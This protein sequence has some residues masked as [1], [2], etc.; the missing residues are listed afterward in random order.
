[1]RF[2]L[3]E[4]GS[5]GRSLA[6]EASTART[7][8]EVL[9]WQVERR[10]DETA[11][12]FLPDGE[13]SVEELSY[14]SLA[15]R[16][17]A[18]AS[19]LRGRF[20]SGDRAIILFESV[21]DFSVAFFGCLYAKVIPVPL[22]ARLNRR[23]ASVVR[24]IA[25]DAGAEVFLSTEAGAS[26]AASLSMLGGMS[27]VTLKDVGES[28]LASAPPAEAYDFAFLQYT[29]GSTNDPKGVMVGHENLLENMRMIRRSF[30]FHERSVMVSWLPHHHDMGLIGTVLAPI[31]LGIPSVLMKPIHFAQNPMRWLRAISRFGGTVSGG[32]DFGYD[33]CSRAHPETV[34]ELDLSSWEVAFSGAEPVRSATLDRFENVF[35]AAG[36]RRTS[37]LPC[38]GLA[39]GTLLAAGRSVDGGAQ[40]Q[41]FD[42]GRLAEGVAE[43]ATDAVTGRDLVGCL[44]QEGTEVAIVN[45]RGQKTEDG[46]AGEIWI[47]G[48][49][50][51]LGYW[52][53]PEESERTFRAGL[54]G[55]GRTYLRTGDIGFR[56]DSTL[57][58]LGRAKDLIIVRGQNHHPEDIET[59]VASCDRG[60]TILRSA[61]FGVDEGHGERVAVLVEIS[62]SDPDRI[63]ALTRRVRQA[64]SEEHGVDA[65]TVLAV[66]PRTIPLTTSGKVRRRETARLYASAHLSPKEGS[67]EEGPERGMPASVAVATPDDGG[68]DK[69]APVLRALAARVLRVRLDALDNTLPLTAQGLDSLKAAEFLELSEHVLGFRPSLEA[70]LG[71]VPLGEIAHAMSVS[72]APPQARYGSATEVD[73]GP[74]PLSYGQRTLWFQQE[75]AVDAMNLNLARAVSIR[76]PLDLDALHEAFRALLARHSALRTRYCEYSGQVWQQPV[77]DVP[78]DIARVSAEAWSSERLT[79][80]LEEAAFEPFSL[81]SPP[82]LRAAVYQRSEHQNILLVV[83]H[84]SVID[85]ESLFT[86]IRSL[87]SAYASATGLSDGGEEPT[88]KALPAEFVRWQRQLVGNETGR[89]LTRYWQDQLE[90]AAKLDLPTDRVRPATRSFRGASHPFR[91]NVRTLHGIKHLAGSLGIGV[92]SLLF[93][94]YAVLLGRYSGEHRFLL[95]FVHSGRTQSYFADLVG[96]LVNLLPIHIDMEGTPAFDMFARDLHRHLIRAYDY[97]DFPYGKMAEEIRHAET[98]VGEGHV[99][100][101]FAFQRA[102][103]TDEL[104]LTPLVLNQ[105]GR[106]LEREGIEIEVH[107]LRQHACYF[108]LSLYIGEDSDELLCALEYSTDL[109]EAETIE[110]LSRA[111]EHLLDEICSAPEREVAVLPLMSADEERQIVE[112]WNDTGRFQGEECVHELFERQVR[113]APDA[114]AVVDENGTTTYRELNETANRL[115]HRLIGEGCGPGTR[116]GVLMERSAT[117]IAVILGI[118]KSGAA[119]VPLDRGYPRQRLEFIFA[120]AGVE[121]LVGPDDLTS[122]Y[123]DLQRIDPDEVALFGETS[124]VGCRAGLDDTAYVV[125][126]SGSTGRPNGVL[127][128]H[129]GIVNRQSWFQ[130]HYPF[131]VGEVG[132]HKTSLSFFDSGGEIFLPLVSGAPLVVASES[133]GRD[134]VALTELLRR[135]RVTRLVAVPSLLKSMLDS[136]PDLGDRLAALRYCHSSGESLPRDVAWRF[137]EQLPNC[138]LIDLYGS[139]EVSADATL[140][141]L[142]SPDEA[143]VIGR[144]LSGVRVYV[145]GPGMVPLPPRFPGEIH[146]AGD[147]LA[148]GYLG[149][150]ELTEAKMVRDPFSKNPDAR[151]FRTGDRAR[152]HVDGNLEYLGRMDHQV[153]I[154][155]HRVEIG[156]I[157]AV[158]GDHPRVRACAVTTVSP[159]GAGEQQLVAALTPTD[160]GGVAGGGQVHRVEGWRQLYDRMYGDAGADEERQTRIWTDSYTGEPFTS[161]VMS[162]W[163]A[164]AMDRALGLEPRNVLE[165]GCGT[166][167]LAL[168]LVGGG[169]SYVGTDF[170]TEGLQVARERLREAGLEGQA[171]LLRREAPD[172]TGLR[173]EGYDTV[174]L[175]SVTQYLP[176]QDYLREVLAA[177]V[178][179]TEEGGNVF[180]GDVR[181]LD[182]SEA[183]HTSV[184][185]AHASPTELVGQIRNRIQRRMAEDNELVVARAFF[186]GLVHEIP[187]VTNVR[188]L[189]KRGRQANELTSF[190]Y[191]VVLQVGD[192]P[193][194]SRSPERLHWSEVGSDVESLAARISSGLPRPLEVRGVTNARAQIHASRVDLLRG[195]R[196]DE[197][198]GLLSDDVMTPELDPESVG[199]LTRRLT[200]HVAVVPEVDGD[201]N[202]M[203]VRVWPEGEPEPL[204]GAVPDRGEGVRAELTNNPLRT[205]SE[206]ELLGD[207]RRH[208]RSRLPEFMVPKLR[209]MREL[210]TTDTGKVSRIEVRRLEEFRLAGSAGQ[211]TGAGEGTVGQGLEAEVTAI[212]QQVLQVEPSRADDN[213]FDIGG[214]SLSLVQVH[215]RLQE[216]T[217]VEF[218]LVDLY[219]HTTVRAIAEFLSRVGSVTPDGRSGAEAGVKRSGRTKESAL[220]IQQR[221]SALAE[222]RRRRGKQAEDE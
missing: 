43:P 133:V 83:G 85:L 15:L 222:R 125:Y 181:D 208:L 80:E 153:Q 77:R 37:F 170:S 38:Y 106:L 5:H 82:L 110:A 11:L 162:E 164:N 57:F 163:L 124:N 216:L 98:N 112:E 118:L 105:S 137:M 46:V 211:R 123:R 117:A 142:R 199:E 186:T 107:P 220:R 104:G 34:Q 17:G 8:T 196:S 78:F 197:P 74:F 108:D 115:A 210:P 201:P 67:L 101:S 141:E 219:E 65:A 52:D 129:R 27:P 140:H 121:I 76:G 159:P 151:L 168:P 204:W 173:P 135:H 4:C 3:T 33:L 95:G 175:N 93:A 178:S 39:E 48:D 91:V 49:N 32:P 177:A 6:T 191:D 122:P 29:S 132:S 119:Y 169:A 161:T 215:L 25:E 30:S 203:C 188:L 136:H 68:D 28:R 195:R 19:E 24:G 58:V 51:A 12:R 207:V 154:R 144:P 40:V 212:W 75:V 7:L 109:F 139:S 72:P 73:D 111:F 172:V 88:G 176:D 206:R 218:P 171:T 213:F 56:K 36:F 86:V 185:L 59:T 35:G 61:A 103:G 174:V 214:N 146:V 167:N 41:R 193:T 21:L 100:A 2:M 134:P 50:V 157:E 209:V 183:F 70:V 130:R 94:A 127:G 189:L 90:D 165:I 1:M 128:L 152:L 202:T 184:V 9:D 79:Q 160:D 44:L 120:D 20:Q 156:E 126:T 158:L 166:G 89:E 18:V 143:G 47:S 131:E 54:T 113:R 92:S 205:D 116:V 10:P 60:E 194:S 190:R 102:R 200:C 55:H 13:G 84:H 16:A 96:Y 69:A 114:P 26:E 97:A 14:A 23:S 187:R 147:G 145:L 180:V 87:A 63:V 81:D 42:K 149:N 53:R 66:A 138:R 150:S 45:E 179:V 31:Y 71:D 182:L 148:G 198:L 64:V 217:G 192:H 155:G 62:E 221:E 99:S 22:P